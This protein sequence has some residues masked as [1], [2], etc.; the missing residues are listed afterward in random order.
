MEEKSFLEKIRM[1]ITPE[2][3]TAFSGVVV[4]VITLMAAINAAQATAKL[5]KI[6]LDNN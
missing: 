5:N 6:E 2:V 4:A 1:Y 3:V